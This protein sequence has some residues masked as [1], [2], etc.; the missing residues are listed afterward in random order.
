MPS[1]TPSEAPTPSPSVNLFYPDQSQ[2]GFESGCLNDGEQPAWMEANPTAWLFSTLDKCCKQHFS[3]NF[4]FC[5]GN[6]DD[7]CARALWYPDWEGDN[8][9][10]VRDGNEPLYM[11]ANKI[12]LFNMK[13]DCCEEHYSYDL[14]TCMGGAA[15]GSSGSKWYADWTSGD[16]TCKNDGKAPEYMTATAVN[17]LYDDQEDCCEYNLVILSERAYS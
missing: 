8:K 14:G 2:S 16:D 11:T 10:C 7:T 3:W 9:G 6:L 1:C 5:M 17:W 13:A 15:G 12:Y 4:D